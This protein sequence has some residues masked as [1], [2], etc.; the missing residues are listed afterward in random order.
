MKPGYLL[1]AALS[2][3][4]SGLTFGSSPAVGIDEDTAAWWKMAALL[5]DD[6][7]EGRDTGSPGYARAASWVAGQFRTAGLQPGG[8]RGSWLQSVPLT[9]VR[10]ETEGTSISV[11]RPSGPDLH[12]EFLHE[13][14]VR[15]TEALPASVQATLAFRG[16]CSAA[17]LKADIAGRIAVCFGTRRQGLPGAAERLRAAAAAGAIGLIN[18]DDPGFT[19]EPARWPAAYARTV[20]I[21]GEPSLPA[22]ALAV[23]NLSSAGFVKLLSNTSLD[24]SQVLQAGAARQPLGAFDIPGKLVAHFHSTQRAYSADNVLALLPGTDRSLRHEVLVVSAHLDGYGFG[25]PVDGDTLYN[26]A[27]DDAAYV[28]TLIRLAQQRHGHGYRRTVL[29]AVF[30]GEEKGLLGSTWFV[31][32][33]TVA[34]ERLIANINL[35]MVRPLFPLKALTM[36]A[37]TDSTLETAVRAVGETRHI[38]IRPDHE[39]ERGLLERADHWPFLQAGIPATTFL[40][41]Y[42]PGTEAERRFR[43]W[44]HVRYHRPQDDMGQP[45]DQQAAQDFNQFFYALTAKVADSESRPVLRADG[46]AKPGP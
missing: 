12:F 24:A 8:E 21:A 45:M 27:F 4:I 2:L 32:H 23:F 17:D 33:P 10:V 9:E 3:A 46:A 26:G 13:I 31:H 43:E 35:D 16:Y 40:F 30:T 11:S 1:F 19:I 29:F 7:M 34:Q 14:T 37:M 5:A 22:P 15:P 36:L 20:R 42:D 18:I 39:S 6:S 28:S 38:E 41:A 25:T 44:Y